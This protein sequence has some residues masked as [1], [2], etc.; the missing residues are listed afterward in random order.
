[1]ES[2]LTGLGSW[3]LAGLTAGLVALPLSLGAMDNPLQ[4]TSWSAALSK[5]ELRTAYASTSATPERQRS[6]EVGPRDTLWSISLAA[7]PNTRITVKQVML[8]I[9]DAN[10]AAFPTGNINEM[11][12]TTRLIIPSVEAMTSRTA[13][14]AD[15]EVRNQNQAWVSGRVAPV[16]NK[17]PAKPAVTAEKPPATTT[18]QAASKTTSEAQEQIQQLETALA[19]R[20]K[21]L[22]KL[23]QDK[24]ELTT[25]LAEMDQQ[26]STLQQLI[27]LKDQQ[28]TDMEKQQAV[29]LAHPSAST[30]T[31]GTPAMGTSTPAVEPQDLA[32]KIKRQ[33]LVYAALA[34]SLGL[35]I[36]LLAALL[37]TRRKLQAAE[38]AKAAPADTSLTTEALGAAFA[39]D[40]ASSKD[41]DLDLNAQPLRSADDLED[42]EG[43]GELDDLKELD[44]LED[45]EDSDEL[46]S[47][48]GLE[49]L[50]DLEALEGLEELE[51]LD[52]LDFNESLK[53]TSLEEDLMDEA[54]LE[55]EKKQPAADALEEA[56]TFIAYG[57]LEQAAGFLQA[58]LAENPSRENLRIKLLEVLVELNDEETF[59]EQRQALEANSASAASLARAAELANFFVAAPPLDETITEPTAEDL[60]SLDLGE[61]DL[62]DLDLG[63]DLADLDAIFPNEEETNEVNDS[64]D[65]LADLDNLAASKDAYAPTLE[66]SLKEED[67]FDLEELSS[68]DLDDLELD[69]SVELDLEKPLDVNELAEQSDSATDFEPV[70]Y[71]SDADDFM[72]ALDSL[73]L[74]DEQVS[75]ATQETLQEPQQAPGVDEELAE[76][77]ENFAELEALTDGL[78]DLEDLDEL[79]SLNDLGDLDL[80]N[81]DDT[82]A[83]QLDL[84]TAYIEMGDKEG[85]REILEKIINEADVDVK[86][87]A[88]QML[89]TLSN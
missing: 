41:F 83:T 36:L 20:N 3:L 88:Q 71:K 81:Y 34:G 44:S 56:E 59:S 74:D 6:V 78:E 29:A 82:L 32:S 64:V 31:R 30:P 54:L 73:S 18:P 86:A 8:A 55:A 49:E 68:S 26:I 72:E 89:E 28:L 13:I 22:Q 14:Q 52:T 65:D 45:Q 51:T 23:E 48:E 1:M 76:L 9:R 19:T 15:E 21:D 75:Q 58:A 33:P 12:V 27:Q 60:G 84:A 77:N 11:E 80:D 47:L 69:M 37:A 35:A 39:E 5:E 53:S 87:T 46:A 2:K 70:E 16:I 40:P 67:S 63:D 79:D 66:A 10:P 38:P 62:S 43:L 24:E 42:L 4:P 57:R 7:R 85:A 50:E 25:R 17:T 61:M